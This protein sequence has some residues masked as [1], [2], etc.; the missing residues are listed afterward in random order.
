MRKLRIFFVFLLIFQCFSLVGTA[1]PAS[2]SWGATKQASYDV[3][4]PGTTLIW[5]DP[6]SQG[7]MNLTTGKMTRGRDADIVFSSNGSDIGAHGIYDLGTVDFNRVEEIE[8][9]GYEQL[10]KAVPGHVYVIKRADGSVA[11]LKI[12]RNL[13]SVITIQYALGEAEQ[14]L[15]DGEQVTYN[16]AVPGVILINNDPTSQGGL[17][18]TTGKMTK[19]KAET[20]IAVYKDDIGSRGIIDLGVIDMNEVDALSIPDSG[21]AKFAKL[22]TGH[23]YITLTHDGGF[24]KFYVAGVYATTV[25]LV[26][27]FIDEDVPGG[28]NGDN[29]DPDFVVLESIELLGPESIGMKPVTLKVIGIS[30]DGEEYEIPNDEVKWKT[31]D[32]TVGTITAKGVFQIT[33]K[34]GE[35]TITATYEGL[36]SELTYEIVALTSIK[37]KQTLKYSP[38]PVTLTV[39]SVYSDKNTGTVNASNVSWKSSNTKV[40]TV[41]SKGIVTFTGNSGKVTITATYQGKTASA[42]VTV[43]N[44]V[45]SLT[46]TTKLAYSKKPVTIALTAIYSDGKK[47]K[48]TKGVVWKSSDTKVAK[49]SSTGVVTFTG[50]NGTVTITA[51][52]QGKTL[53]LKTTVSLKENQQKAYEEFYGKWKLWIPGSVSMVD[54]K[55]A[56][57]ASNGTLTINKDGTYQL[58]NKKGKWRAAKST[59]VFDNPVAIILTGAGG[60]YDIAVTP[61]SSKK[62]YIK[63]LTDSKGTYTD[64]SKIWIFWSEGSK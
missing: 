50:Q 41:S 35:V 37:F 59:E 21:F 36:K 29:P 15:P 56:P 11:K 26:Y 13:N 5:T 33:G 42:T 39:Q 34:A 55:F 30:E 52:Y 48:L 3:S 31:S 4:V 7:G 1:A 43:G 62:G 60:D 64:G 25:E 51:T 58:N 9:S 44:V 40:A 6:L 28:G 24:V 53:N 8:D 57:G 19:T 22:K 14:E 18:F 23:V 61:H 17:N 27:Q 32:K 2:V 45:K 20:D 49:V 12:I 54:G 46:T 47:V 10:I 16:M 63:L 38:T